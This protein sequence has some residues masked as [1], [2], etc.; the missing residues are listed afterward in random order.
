MILIISGFC[1][2]FSGSWHHSGA[3]SIIEWFSLKTRNILI[4]TVG[5][6]SVT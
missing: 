4:L 5:S 1:I 2:I 6:V 3:I